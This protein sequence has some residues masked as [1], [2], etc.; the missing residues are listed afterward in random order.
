MHAALQ[1]RDCFQGPLH[2]TGLSLPPDSL[3]SK[4]PCDPFLPSCLAVEFELGHFPLWAVITSPST[5]GFT[6][7][8]SCHL[9]A[10]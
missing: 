4:G 2:R 8:M 7:P 9:A 5:W 10:T 3:L 1:H 6:V